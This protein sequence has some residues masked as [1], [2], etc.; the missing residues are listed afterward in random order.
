MADNYAYDA[1]ATMFFPALLKYHGQY[2]RYNGRYGVTTVNMVDMM[3]DVVDIDFSDI[4]M[5]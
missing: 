2:G 5:G 4:A 3:V 1:C